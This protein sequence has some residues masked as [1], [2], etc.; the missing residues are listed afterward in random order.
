MRFTLIFTLNQNI[1]TIRCVQVNIEAS[2]RR[3]N[4][5]AIL[6]HGELSVVIKAPIGAAALIDVAPCPVNHGRIG[7]NGFIFDES[8]EALFD[9]EIMIRNPPKGS[10]LHVKDHIRQEEQSYRANINAANGQIGSLR[11]E[12]L[13][14]QPLP[15][16]AA[17]V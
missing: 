6:D 10:T 1:L 4:Q 9:V 11:A 13:R 3:Q 5:N 2:R 8:G 15:S 14:Y 7:W 12:D 17:L 16:S